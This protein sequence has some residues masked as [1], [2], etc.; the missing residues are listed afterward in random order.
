MLRPAERWDA[1]KQD[2]ECQSAICVLPRKPL[3]GDK[4]RSLP[5]RVPIVG[6]GGRILGPLKGIDGDSPNDLFPWH[7]NLCRQ[8]VQGTSIERIAYSAT[9]K[10]EFH[11]ME[12]FAKLWRK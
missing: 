6:D 12:K 7:F 9:G 1:P 5:L 3:D 10:D 8:R 4:Q 11:G 2:G